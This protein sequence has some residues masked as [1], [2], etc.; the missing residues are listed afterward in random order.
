METDI[1]MLINSKADVLFLPDV[2]D[3]Y[4]PG[5]RKDIG[6]RSRIIGIGHGRKISARSF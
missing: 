1:Q 4:P 3:I 2:D 5:I 6:L